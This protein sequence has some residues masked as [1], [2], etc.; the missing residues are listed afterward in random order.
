MKR[1]LQRLFNR[2][3]ARGQG[4]SFSITRQVH[5]EV[6]AMEERMLLSTARPSHGHKHP[7]HHHDKHALYTQML[8]FPSAFSG[9]VLANP[10]QLLLSLEPLPFFVADTHS[11][12]NYTERLNGH[13]DYSVTMP[14]FDQVR[15]DLGNEGRGHCVPTSA[16]DVMAFLANHGHPEVMPGLGAQQDWSNPAVYDGVTGVISSMGGAMGTDP[17]K[18]TLAGN[19]LNGL[20]HWLDSNSPHH[21][22]VDDCG[23]DQWTIFRS[24]YVPSI[25]EMVGLASK[26]ALVIAQ[27]G[28]YQQDDAGI[29]RHDHGHAFVLTEAHGTYGAN[30]KVIGINDPYW[31][32][33]NFSPETNPNAQSNFSTDH[34]NVTPVVGTFDD[35]A[36][37]TQT[38][39]RVVG[40]GDSAYQ[41]YLDEYL[42]V[43]PLPGANLTS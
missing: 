43:T 6:E 37:L 15:A 25:D 22:Q 13:Y 5:L 29:W 19:A 23:M 16:V 3:G 20:R 1:F 18:G 35:D 28:F 36:T 41:A 21:F 9:V 33:W 39:E 11:Y 12:Y 42:V 7:G 10:P 31:D 38:R 4:P 24:N 40:L 17:N 2:G 32:N 30:D 26:G 14:D 8:P 27:V 34:Y